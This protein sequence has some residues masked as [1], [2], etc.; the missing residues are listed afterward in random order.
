MNTAPPRATA[1]YYP[2]PYNLVPTLPRGNAV[3]DAP[4][5]HAFHRLAFGCDI[6]HA[7]VTLEELPGVQQDLDGV[8][9]RKDGEPASD[10]AGEEMGEAVISDPV[11]CASHE[12]VYRAWLTQGGDAERL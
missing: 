6:D 7:I 3:F 2:Q 1:V 8:G 11:S 4:A 5:S 9:P 12:I 10:R